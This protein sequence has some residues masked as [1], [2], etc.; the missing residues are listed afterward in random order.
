[1]SWAELC[2]GGDTASTPGID[3]G[4]CLHRVDRGSGCCNADFVR[5]GLSSR[6]SCTQGGEVRK[7]LVVGPSYSSA[8]A[9]SFGFK[10]SKLPSISRLSSRITSSSIGRAIGLSLTKYRA[11]KKGRGKTLLAGSTMVMI[12]PTGTM[13][14]SATLAFLAYSAECTDARAVSLLNRRLLRSSYEAMK[15]TR[16]TILYRLPSCGSPFA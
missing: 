11:A 9:N 4:A 10:P 16:P 1:M 6:Y 8:R 5:A 7:L 14:W 13:H 12:V 3:I 15:Y 2:R